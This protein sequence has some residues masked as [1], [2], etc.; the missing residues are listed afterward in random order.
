MGG[1]DIFL[2]QD[3]FGQQI[4]PTGRACS[5]SPAP[6]VAVCHHGFIP[7][8]TP[9]LRRRH[10][11]TFSIFIRQPH[12]FA[13]RTRTSR[14]DEDDSLR[15]LENRCAHFHAPRR[16]IVIGPHCAMGVSQSLG[17]HSR[18]FPLPTTGASPDRLAGFV[19]PPA[20]PGPGRGRNHHGWQPSSSGQRS[21]DVCLR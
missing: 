7:G 12:R 14:R 19:I 10:E 11:N 15:S 17:C 13:P 6:Q 9:S 3:S 16:R 2:A 20:A 18:P 4:G 21:H 1:G 8:N 5:S